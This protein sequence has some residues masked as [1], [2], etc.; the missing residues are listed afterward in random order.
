MNEKELGDYARFFRE[1]TWQDF[2]LRGVA[3]TGLALVLVTKGPYWWG[4]HTLEAMGVVFAIGMAGIALWANYIGW[5]WGWR[6]PQVFRTGTWWGG[7]AGVAVFIGALWLA[8]S[9]RDTLPTWSLPWGRL[10]WIIPVLIALIAIMRVV[11]ERPLRRPGGPDNDPESWYAQLEQAL[12]R[13]NWWS[14]EDARAAVE[15]ARERADAAQ[16]PPA[17]ALGDAWRYARDLTRVHPSRPLRRYGRFS[18]VFSL[19]VTVLVASVAIGA[20][21]EGSWGT[22]LLVGGLALLLGAGTL[23]NW[24]KLR[25]R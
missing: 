8:R 12:R 3:I 25:A 17:E 11:P 16:L 10:W 14:R 21:S 5:M 19:V 7:L 24:R 6:G 20:V 9:V 2:A 4:T 15:E 22:A 1:V 23:A 13:Q 18:F